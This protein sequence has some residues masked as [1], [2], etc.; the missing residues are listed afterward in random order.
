[1]KPTS[2][3]SKTAEE[4][5]SMIDQLEVDEKIRVFR[6]ILGSVLGQDV[7][8]RVDLEAI[9]PKDIKLT[10]PQLARLLRRKAEELRSTQRE[11]LW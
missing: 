6:Y 3:D 2:P 10:T 5:I 8:L 9:P 1:M 11:E 7:K 4:V